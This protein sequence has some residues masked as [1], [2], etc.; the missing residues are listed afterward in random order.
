MYYAMIIFFSVCDRIEQKIITGFQTKQECEDVKK[1]NESIRD[2]VNGYVKDEKYICI[3][4][5]GVLPS[6]TK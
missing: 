5:N 4:Y 6:I 1:I 3:S 2:Q